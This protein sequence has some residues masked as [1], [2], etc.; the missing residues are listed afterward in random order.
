V[1][2]A[3]PV[4]RVVAPEKALIPA[5]IREVFQ[6]EV[7]LLKETKLSHPILISLGLDS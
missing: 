5:L 7:R 6:I 2:C 4:R 1:L 3:G